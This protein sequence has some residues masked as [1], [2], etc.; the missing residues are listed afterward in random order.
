MLN[1][2]SKQ[3][4]IAPFKAKTLRL[5][6]KESMMARRQTRKTT[7]VRRRDGSTPAKAI[8]DDQTARPRGYTSGRTGA[9]GSLMR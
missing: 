5:A 7:P 4:S 8:L 6:G 3:A 9:R 2:T 1:H